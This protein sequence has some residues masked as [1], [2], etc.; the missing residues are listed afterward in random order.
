MSK[1]WVVVGSMFG[2][3]FK[4]GI[5]EKIL[6]IFLDFV[7][8]N[9]VIFVNWELIIK[10]NKEKWIRFCFKWKI[11]KIILDFFIIGFL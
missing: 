5:W 11:D 10:K 9:Y 4:R 1:L 3:Y 2:N 8:S 6:K 7:I